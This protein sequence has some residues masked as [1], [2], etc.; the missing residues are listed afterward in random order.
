MQRRR[1]DMRGEKL[2]AQASPLIKRR[3]R[4]SSSSETLLQAG[5]I[6][7]GNTKSE[8]MEIHKSYSRIPA[9]I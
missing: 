8:R 3:R 2:R 6:P 4:L 1:G 7:H 9:G 5:K